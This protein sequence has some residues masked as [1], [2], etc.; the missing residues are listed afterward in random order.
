MQLPNHP[1]SLWCPAQHW[2]VKHDEQGTPATDL[3]FLSSYWSI[4]GIL[5]CSCGLMP[6]AWHLHTGYL[7]ML[8]HFMIGC[9]QAGLMIHW[10]FRT[11]LHKCVHAHPWLYPI[12]VCNVSNDI[13]VFFCICSTQCC[14]IKYNIDLLE[15][16][17]DGWTKRLPI[18]P[19]IYF[20]RLAFL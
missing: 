15:R 2:P 18:Q 19:H 11:P 17:G 14:S 7:K 5:S 8:A 4:R 3:F 16:K 13:F 12:L 10:F 6:R 20:K 9:I 1:A